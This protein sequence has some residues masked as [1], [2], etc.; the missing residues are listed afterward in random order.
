MVGTRPKDKEEVTTGT[1]KCKTFGTVSA[2]AT[3][4]DEGGEQSTDKT[5][6]HSARP[7]TESKVPPV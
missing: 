2:I 1:D 6:G 7:V 4:A 3:E 5:A